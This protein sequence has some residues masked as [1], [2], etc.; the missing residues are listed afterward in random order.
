MS[1][2]NMTITVRYLL[3]ATILSTAIPSN[4]VACSSRYEN[5]F[6]RAE[7][8]ATIAVGYAHGPLSARAD[9]VIAGRPLISRRLRLGNRRDI[10]SPSVERGDVL[11][12]LDRRGRLLSWSGGAENAPPPELIDAVRRY[13]EGP[14]A[15][16]AV[17]LQ[18]AAR[19]DGSRLAIDAASAL[20]NRPELLVAL[21][22]AEREA[23]ELA[24]TRSEGANA[25][26]LAAVVARLDRPNAAHAII[27]RLERLPI[28]SSALGTYLEIATTH[29]EQLR[30]AADHDPPSVRW[31]AYREQRLRDR[32]SADVTGERVSEANELVRFRDW[33]ARHPTPSTLDATSL[34]DV[35][36]SGPDALS[37]IVAIERCE[38][39]HRRR[40]AASFESYALAAHELDWAVFAE[41]CRTGRAAP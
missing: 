30:G 40:L 20:A 17:L 10:C 16:R 13:R 27:D 6:E 39:V 32:F 35:V 28:E 2:S 34:A 33:I 21:T 36:L 37:R 41:A 11:L 3:A 38:R 5:V 7:R 18:Y 31:Q 23:L 15:A 19:G 14:L 25:I 24:M 8:A 1:V 26:A 29:R 4:A 12:F 9:E 22:D